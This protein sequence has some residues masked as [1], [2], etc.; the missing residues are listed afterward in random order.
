MIEPNVTLW[1]RGLGPA[2]LV[3]AGGIGLAERGPCRGVVWLGPRLPDLPPVSQVPRR[4][5][6][7]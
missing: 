7:S 1:G 5:R 6:V 2:H 3:R 4:A